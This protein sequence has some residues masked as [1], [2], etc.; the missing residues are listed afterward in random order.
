MVRP[1]ALTLFGETTQRLQRRQQLQN[2][3]RSCGF[4]PL[5]N[6]SGVDSPAKLLVLKDHAVLGNVGMRESVY[7]NAEICN[8]LNNEDVT[9]FDCSTLIM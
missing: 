8:I 5:Y 4:T 6:S 7:A 9:N 3:F 1:N 2:C